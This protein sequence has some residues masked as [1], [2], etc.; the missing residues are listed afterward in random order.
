MKKDFALPGINIHG[1]ID[2]PDE[3]FI[4]G[5]NQYLIELENQLKLWHYWGG[6]QIRT[7]QGTT[8]FRHPRRRPFG[9][10]SGDEDPHPAAIS[11]LKKALQQPDLFVFHKGTPVKLDVSGISDP[12]EQNKAKEFL[13]RNSPR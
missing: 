4:L 5:D 10:R 1:A 9:P 7:V 11:L 8:F 13:T 3:D 6:E 2:F 12:T